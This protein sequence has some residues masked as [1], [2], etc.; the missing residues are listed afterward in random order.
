MNLYEI[1]HIIDPALSEEEL[2]KEIEKLK[3][4]I[5]GRGGNILDLDEI[6]R[7]QLAY[8]IKKRTDGVY[9]LI[10]AELPPEAIAPLKDELRLRESIL[11]TLIIRRKPQEI[12]TDQKEKAA[13]TQES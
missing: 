11:R 1:M 4:D 13:Q 10:N 8:E 5:T 12:K 3:S 9:L 7:R 6:G 2:E